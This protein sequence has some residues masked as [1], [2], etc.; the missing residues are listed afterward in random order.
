M[1]LFSF[2]SFSQVEEILVRNAED[3]EEEI[4]IFDDRKD[5]SKFRKVTRELISTAAISLQDLIVGGSVQLFTIE[6]LST[7]IILQNGILKPEYIHHDVDK[8]YSSMAKNLPQVQTAKKNILTTPLRHWSMTK[9]GT[10]IAVPANIE[11]GSISPMSFYSRSEAGRNGYVQVTSPINEYLYKEDELVDA[12]VSKL[13]RGFKAVRKVKISTKPS[14]LWEE[15]PFGT[16][17]THSKD[18]VFVQRLGA[19][20]KIGLFNADFNY[21]AVYQFTGVGTMKIL[22]D[23]DRKLIKLTIEKKKRKGHGRQGAYEMEYGLFEVGFIKAKLNV[24]FVTSSREK[25][26]ASDLI[27]EYIYDIGY[28]GAEE[29][30]QEALKGKLEKTQALAVDRGGVDSY[31][32]ILIERDASG[33]IHDLVKRSRFGLSINENYMKVM[34]ALNRRS[35][36]KTN[37]LYDEYV[38]I[39]RD[40]SFEEAD[41]YGGKKKTYNYEHMN[42]KY[43]ASFWRLWGKFYQSSHISAQIENK[44]SVIPSIG[45]AQSEHFKLKYNFNLEI[46]KSS[47]RLK[48]LFY[49]PI[50]HIANLSNILMQENG[51][52]DLSRF[53]SDDK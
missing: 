29:A 49:E 53:C 27:H 31:M 19:E 24:K 6:N 51:D 23:P 25:S 42:T 16:E 20:K 15:Y 17:I 38:K 52:F 21:F 37:Y 34:D 7:G 41:D 32:G 5:L 4:L 43:K 44:I 10:K 12:L 33:V 2:Q 8:V 48:K 26:R 45:P 47:K 11:L 36:S 50:S 13:K 1:T 30:L 40:S 14:K 39:D 9:V 18:F 3:E 28:P 46:R 22:G 35:K